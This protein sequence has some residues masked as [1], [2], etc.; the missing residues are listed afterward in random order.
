M[1]STSGKMAAITKATLSKVYATASV[2]G[3][4]VIN[5]TAK[6]TEGTTCL[7]RSLGMAC[8]YGMKETTTK[9]TSTTI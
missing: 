2:F 3:R 8:T 7:I 9:G 1:A 4:R 6:A 5:L